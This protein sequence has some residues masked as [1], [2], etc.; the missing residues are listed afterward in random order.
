M[1]LANV[2]NIV[3]P[4][5]D[6]K[7]QE[8]INPDQFDANNGSLA[9]KINEILPFINGQNLNYVTGAPKLSASASTDNILSMIVS[10]G[11]GFHTLYASSVSQGLPTARSFRGI[12]QITSVG[13]GWAWM[14]DSLNNF[15]TNYL[16]AGVWSGWRTYIS[17]APPAWTT[18]PLSGVVQA[19]STGYTPRY[20][21]IGNTVYIEGAVKNIS[22]INTVV[23]TLPTGYRPGMTASFSL[24]TSGKA[25]A[26]WAV[27]TTGVIQLENTTDTTNP[28][29]VDFFP[30]TMSFLAV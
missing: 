24:P 9:S 27:G 10:E 25:H 15:Y 5:A 22:A 19:Y 12:S 26:R 6:F 18:L 4:Y 8:I 28:T 11:V 17:D 2:N 20:T 1:T 30:L 3:L 21:K 7:F 29:T 23:S 13:Y 14:T 16:D